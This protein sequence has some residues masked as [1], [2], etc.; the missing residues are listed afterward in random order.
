MAAA[1]LMSEYRLSGIAMAEHTLG[2]A[3][4]SQQALDELMSKDA[5]DAAYEIAE[6]FAWRG[7]KDRAFEWLERAYKQRDNQLP[8]IKYDPWMKSLRAD[9][10]F[11]A[12]LRK[13]KLPESVP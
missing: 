4:E 11:K 5:R 3:K 2:H 12:L 9:P 8:D 7:E 10:R 13:M 1:G 6:V